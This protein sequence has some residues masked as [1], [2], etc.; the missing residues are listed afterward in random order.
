M[1]GQLLHYL[2][3]GLLRIHS[4]YNLHVHGVANATLSIE[5][6]S[7]FV[8]STT[9]SI[10]T[11]WNEPVPGRALSRGRTSPFHGAHSTSRE[12]VA[13]QLRILRGNDIRLKSLY[14]F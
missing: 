11:G 5:G 14:V 12:D 4:S 7:S 2:F 8:A 6:F 10:V 3:R 1:V 9:A 13:I